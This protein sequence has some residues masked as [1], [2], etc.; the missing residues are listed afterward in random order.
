MVHRVIQTKYHALGYVPYGVHVWLGCV[1]M[2]HVKHESPGLRRVQGQAH[3]VLKM[4][5]AESVLNH[6]E[7]GLGR[8]YRH[9]FTQRGFSVVRCPHEH[10][11][12]NHLLDNL[13]GPQRNLHLAPVVCGR[14]YPLGLFGSLHPHG[15]DAPDDGLHTIAHVVDNQ[16]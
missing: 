8:A 16:P 10:H 1:G 6:L 4:G 9:T 2:F 11:P 3:Q 13:N 7:S 12:W 14:A 5:I 15:W